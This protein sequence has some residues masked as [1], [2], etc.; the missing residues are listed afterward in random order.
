MKPILWVGFAAFWSPGKRPRF[1]ALKK[2]PKSNERSKPSKVPMETLCRLGD[3]SARWFF[4]AILRRSHAASPKFLAKIEDGFMADMFIFMIVE[5]TAW[6]IE[7]IG[8]PWWYHRVNTIW[9]PGSCG[10]SHL[11]SCGV[12]CRLANSSSDRAVVSDLP[13]PGQKTAS[14]SS[15]CRREL[16]VEK[17]ISRKVQFILELCEST[18]AHASLQCGTF[19]RRWTNTSNPLC[20]LSNSKRWL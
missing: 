10:F 13:D 20:S 12:V 17:L 9:S 8:V 5:F 7:V 14:R 6:W 18:R 1:F 2:M 15:A 16:R 11:F 3:A 19:A 4:F